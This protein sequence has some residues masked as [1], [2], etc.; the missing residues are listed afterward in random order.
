MK[1]KVRSDRFLKSSAVLAL[2][3]YGIV[4]RHS[5]AS[6]RSVTGWRWWCVCVRH[7]NVVTQKTHLK[8][9]HFY[10]LSIGQVRIEGRDECE[11]R[12]TWSDF[13]NGECTSKMLVESQS[14]RRKNGCACSGL[15]WKKMYEQ[16]TLKKKIHKEKKKKTSMNNNSVLE[17]NWVAL[18]CLLAMPNHFTASHKSTT[19]LRFFFHSTFAAS[20]FWFIFSTSS[21]L[22]VFSK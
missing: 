16:R 19:G 18:S 21:L 13:S 15:A 4:V 9:E 11:I 14:R 3:P 10:L 17:Q 6:H 8:Q 7:G 22:L 5:N 1:K 20:T 2:I 12:F